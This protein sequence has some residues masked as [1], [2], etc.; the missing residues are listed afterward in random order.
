MQGAH[1]PAHNRAFASSP[2]DAIAR[3]FSLS[4]R[5]QSLFRIIDGGRVPR[6]CA[7]SDSQESQSAMLRM[8]AIKDGS[9]S[10]V[11]IIINTIGWASSGFQV[12]EPTESLAASLM[13][14]EVRGVTPTAPWPS[15]AVMVPTGLVAIEGPDGPSDVVA[16]LINVSKCQTRTVRIDAYSLCGVSVHSCFEDLDALAEKDRACNDGYVHGPLDLH[17]VSMDERANQMIYRLLVGLMLEL[18]RSPPGSE[19]AQ[20][21]PRRFAMRKG[22]SVASHWALIRPVTVDC[23]ASVREFVAMGGSAPTVRTMVRGH[24]KRQVCGPGGTDRRLVR[25]EPYWRGP[26]DGPVAVRS[27][28]V[29]ERNCNVQSAVEDE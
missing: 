19:H 7:A 28:V 27:H 13:S 5:N 12:I 3:L 29:G 14:T 17:M 26:D 23:R 18:E 15:F 9:Q 2:R 6:V 11:D 25:I 22:K 21:R 16:I 10:I 20:R 24:W 4:V 8:V 1:G